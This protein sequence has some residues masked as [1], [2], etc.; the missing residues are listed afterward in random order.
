MM[1]FRKVTVADHA[2]ELYRMDVAA[3]NRPFDLPS[4]SVQET[5]SYLDGCDVY[6]GYL[7]AVPVGLAAF[8]KHLGR[9]EIKQVLI[10]PA[11]QRKGYGAQLFRHMLAAIGPERVWLVTHPKNTPAILLYLKE[12]FRISGWNENYYGDGQPRLILEKE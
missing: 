7:G 6:L 4:R 11:Y 9:V 10:L 5:V 3:F 12:G 1:T 2:E 8:K